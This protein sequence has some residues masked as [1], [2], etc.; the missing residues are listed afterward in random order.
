MSR[1]NL[2]QNA[3]FLVAT[4][5]LVLLGPLCS[6]GLE[7]PEARDQADKVRNMEQVPDLKRL[8]EVALQNSPTFMTAK[9]AY[10]VSRLQT[11]NAFASFLPSLDFSSQAGPEGISPYPVP[12]SSL[13]VG[14]ANPWSSSTSLTLTE[15]LY[16]N[17]ESL[18][19]H[20]IA[21]WNQ[22]LN[23][24]NLQKVKGQVL[25]T[26]VQ[27][28]SEW[29]YAVKQLRFTSQYSKELERLY[30][31][32]SDQ[33]YQ[34]LKT[35]SDFM[36]FQTQFQKSQLDILAGQHT[37]EVNRLTLI[38]AM[39]LSSENSVPLYVLEQ[40]QIHHTAEEL[41]LQKAE[42]L[43]EKILAVKEK[44]S[45][46]Q[47]DLISRRNLPQ[48]NLTAG[49]QYGSGSYIQ[50][51]QSWSDNQQTG[52][53]LGLALKWNLWDWGVRA[54]NVEI[55]RWQETS[56]QQDLR[57]LQINADKDLQSYRDD[58]RQLLAKTSI[59]KSLETNEKINY[60]QFDQD[61]RM[62]RVTYLDLI[63]ALSNLLDSQNRRIR[64]EYDTFILERKWLYYK[65]SLDEN[66]M[67]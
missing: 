14:G 31:L 2:K 63:G 27:A 62:G 48:L 58:Q 1:Y 47:V 39:G 43:E 50:T 45:E 25:L 19:L 3:S 8:A 22:E 59:T 5:V 20:R 41:S 24:L 38:A 60:K 7:G 15:T 33:Y 55:Q 42:L 12:S 53:N 44:M 18:K 32:A 23:L 65:G 4:A 61:Y 34:G 40:P 13:S 17:G 36:R 49:A 10:E 66:S 37:V 46:S 57:S 26:L 35:Q 54:R 52:W 11:K 6:F 9:A 51:G 30:K 56:A 67:E 16:D 21:N 64:L 28:Y 29:S